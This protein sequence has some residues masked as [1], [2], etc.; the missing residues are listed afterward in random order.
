MSE[1]PTNPSWRVTQTMTWGGETQPDLERA[2]T[3]QFERRGTFAAIQ[4]A[5]RNTLDLVRRSSIFDVYEK[6]KARGVK[7]QRKKWV[8][9]L[10]EY[11]FYAILLAFVYFVLIGV[12]LWNGA[13]WWL[14]WV[15]QHKFVI[16]GGFSITVGLAAL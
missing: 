9:V 3:S 4:T 12:P 7:L 14:W 2:E 5:A 6:A 16:A 15:V 1:I 13:V 10:F 8:E 11:S